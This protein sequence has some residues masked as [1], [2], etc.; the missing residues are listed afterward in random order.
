MFKGTKQ[1]GPGVFNKIVAGVGGRDNAFTSHD[2][3]A[4]FQQVPADQLGRMMQL[5]AD[6]MSSLMLRDEDFAKEVESYNF[7]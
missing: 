7:V 1:V 6:R 5:E 4:Y 2:Y 3:T